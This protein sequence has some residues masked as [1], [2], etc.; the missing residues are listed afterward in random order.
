ML[1]GYDHAFKEWNGYSTYMNED[2][3]Q[4]G[5]RD[6]VLVDALSRHIPLV[7]KQPTII[8][9]VDVTHPHPGEDSSPSIV[10]VIAT[11]D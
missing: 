10:V 9:G 6:I 1:Y 8:F 5:G 2:D 4:V 3:M 11:Q 7:S